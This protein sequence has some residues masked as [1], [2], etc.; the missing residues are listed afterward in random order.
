VKKVFSVLECTD[1]GIAGTEL[2]AFWK[3]DL[4]PASYGKVEMNAPTYVGPL[5]T[6]NSV[7]GPEHYVLFGELD[8]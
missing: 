3:R 6:A 7:T 4:F 2:L 1:D 8:Y 5:E